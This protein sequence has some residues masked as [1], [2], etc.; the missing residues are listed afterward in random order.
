MHLVCTP[1]TKMTTRE[2]STEA[3]PIDSSRV[4]RAGSVPQG[5]TANWVQLITSVK[6]LLGFAVLV[7]LIS[8]VIL[9]VLLNDLPTAEKAG[10]A[11][12]VPLFGGGVWNYLCF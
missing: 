6:T 1:G 7:L 5:D 11:R 4:P 9:L 8:Q 10:L 3:G 2:R 12:W